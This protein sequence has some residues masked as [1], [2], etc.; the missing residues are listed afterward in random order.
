MD[1]K[2]KN[3][4]IEFYYQVSSSDAD[5][6]GNLVRKT[7]VFSEEEIS[8]ARELVLDEL[9]LSGSYCF[10]LQRINENLVAYSC[11]GR[12]PFTDNRFDL[13]WIAVDPDNQKM[14]LASAIYK[15]TEYEIIK[16]GGQII[17]AETS[18]LPKYQPA[19]QFYLKSGFVQVANFKDF[20]KDGD[21]K[22]VF[23]KNLKKTTRH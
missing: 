11:Y 22:I 15:K 23:A 18:S 12:I 3:L 6:I 7:G 20:Y 5:E 17:Y 1:K 8:V 2:Q 14:G 4:K 9:K 16:L 21:D 10:I 19:R 13:Y